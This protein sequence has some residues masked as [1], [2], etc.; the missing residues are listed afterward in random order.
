MQRIATAG[1][2]KRT[3]SLLRGPI[4]QHPV[5][6]LGF[7]PLFLLAG[8]FATLIIPLW[9]AIFTR[10]I[11]AGLLWS[12]AFALFVIHYTP[13]LTRPPIDGKPG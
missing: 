7:R 2:K 6:K 5:F 10:L 3:H 12:T 9:L 13:I 4:F 11:A 1:V 8:G